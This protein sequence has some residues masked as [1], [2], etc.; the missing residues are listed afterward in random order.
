MEHDGTR[1]WQLWVPT[2]KW[3]KGPEQDF[4]QWEWCHEHQSDILHWMTSEVL[5]LQHLQHDSTE[6]RSL[7][8]MGLHSRGHSAHSNCPNTHTQTHTQRQG[9]HT[10]CL[11]FCTDKSAGRSLHVWA[12]KKKKFPYRFQLLL[13]FILHSPDVLHSQLN[14]LVNPTEE[15]AVE[16]GK[17]PFFLL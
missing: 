10:T 3:Q 9:H 2:N 7:K 12:F 14:P 6:C 15:L 11:S 13:G 16:V 8:H 1:Q 4:V 5:T 17:Y